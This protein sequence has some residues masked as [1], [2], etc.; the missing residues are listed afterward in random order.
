V[1]ATWI[2][3][4]GELRALAGSLTVSRALA[5]DSES[6]SLH[7][8][9][10]KVCLVQYATDRGAAGLVDPLAVRDL[11]PLAPVLAD[12]GV[13][14]VLHG[15]DYDVTTMKRDFGFRFANLFDTM[16]AARFLGMPAIGLQAVLKAELGVDLAKDSQKDDWSRRPL[17]PRQETYAIEDVRHLLEVHRRLE[18]RLSQAGRLSWVVEECEAV[19]ALEPARRKRDPDAWQKVKG[20]RR[21]TPRR[22]AV[23]RELHAWRESVAEATDLPPFRILGPD[24]MMAIAERQPL[25]VAEL[26]QLRGLSPRVVREPGPVLEAVAR[27]SALDEADL[28]RLSSPPRRVPS[29]ET[30]RRSEALRAWRTDEA[31]RVGLDVSVVLPQRLLDRVAEAAPRDRDAL[32]AIE[33]LR[34]WRVGAFGEGILAALRKA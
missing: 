12:P 31:G 11:S 4:P 22:Q 19:A 32:G 24:T 3:T 23:L 2:R 21:L 1:P 20:V 15:A 13:V 8:H 14:K 25:S 29:A 33:G 7:H 26:R 30:R 10:E 9:F 28:P 27:A 6:D 34:R 17:T 16:L 18:A 5:L